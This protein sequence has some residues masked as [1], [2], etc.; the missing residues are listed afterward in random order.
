LLTLW[1]ST[2]FLVDYG[3]IEGFVPTFADLDGG[4]AGVEL[5]VIDHWL[6]ARAARC[7][8][9]ATTALER[10]RVD[11]LVEAFES[12]V[13]DLS[14]WYIRRTRRRFYDLDEAA[15]RTLWVGIV[16]A[17]RMISPVMPFLTD[18]LWKTLVADT[19]PD[20]PD[21]I[22]LAGWPQPPTARDDDLLR[23][24]AVARDVVEVGR[25]ARSEAKVRLRQ[26]LRT[27]A[28]RGAEPARRHAIEIAEELRVKEVAFDVDSPVETSYKPNFP[29]AGPRLGSR[30]KDVAAAITSGD[31]TVAEDGSISAAGE[32]LAPDEV[33]RVERVTREGW[34]VAHEGDIGVAVDLTLDDELLAEGQAL[35][36]IRTLNDLRKQQGLALTD[37]IRVVLPAEHA[38]VVGR[39][40]DWIAAEV[41]AVE[42]S[43]DEKMTEPHIEVEQD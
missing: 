38:D 18:H 24:M 34:A 15:F 27:A 36:L 22:H 28:V 32:T 9:D 35:D 16:T 5:R 13:E 20:A 21:S 40:G 12:Y 33:I 17:L 7:V 29:V 25:R 14:N 30:I 6:L 31:F 37:R 4:P 19:C 23:S 39:H 41:L 10:W 26:P 8:D 3:N 2:R 1:N 11:E 43:V 42:L